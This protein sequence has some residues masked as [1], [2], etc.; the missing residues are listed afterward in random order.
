MNISKLTIVSLFFIFSVSQMQAVHIAG[1]DI[2]Y[3]NVGQDSFLV[4]LNLFRDCS[5]AVPNSSENIIFTS[6]CGDNLSQ[7]LVRQSFF[8]VS[9][10]CTNSI[11]NSTC[12]G[13]SLSAYEQHVYSGIVVLPAL[14]NSWTM[15]WLGCCRKGLVSNLVNSQSLYIYIYASLYSALD[16]TNTSPYF[17]S[18]PSPI[19][20]LNQAT[21]FNFGA[22]DPDGDSLVYSMSPGYDNAT[23]LIPYL[24][25]YT[26]NQPLPG[27]NLT[28]D[29]KTGQINFT[30]TALG[31]YT[32][33]VRVSEYDRNTGLLLGSTSRD[34][35]VVVTNS[36]QS[37]PV[38]SAVGM[39]NLGDGSI[40]NGILHICHG[41]S[42]NFNITISDADLADSLTVTHSV[43]DV[44]D[45]SAR[46]TVIGTNPVVI[47]VKWQ[48]F[49]FIPREFYLWFQVRDSG[50]PFNGVV[51]KAF[52]FQYYD[53][54]YANV[55]TTICNGDSIQLKAVGGT[56][57]SWSVISGV[58]IN[59]NPASSGYNA[60]CFQC[61]NPT[62][63]PTS[64]TI[65]RVVSNTNGP[66]GNVDTVI[67]NV[68]N[69]YTLTLP[70]DT[71]ICSS[72]EIGLFVHCLPS[73]SNY[74]YLWSNRE[75]LNDSTIANPI[76]LP[77]HTQR[78]T[79][80]VNNGSGC[81][82]ENSVKITL[83]PSIPI[84]FF[85]NGDSII[86]LGQSLDLDIDYPLVSSASTY[87]STINSVGSTTFSGIIGSGSS[88]TSNTGFPS[89]YGRYYW[90]SKHQLLY[91]VAE[92]NAMGMVAGSAINSI[93]FDVVS[94]G[95]PNNMDNMSIRIG[96]TSDTV[97]NGGF[98]SGLITV[99]PNHIYNTVLG[100]NVHT[101]S[102]GYLWDGVSSVVVEICSNNSGYS[103]L[104][105]SITR[106]STTSH[107][108]VVYYRGDN[109][110]VC[111]NSTATVSYNRPNTKFEY[112]AT[113]D[114][115][116]YSYTWSPV[117]GS[118]SSS[119]IHA[120]V[121]P[122]SDI[123]Y[124]VMV[125]DS[126]GLCFDTVTKNIT[127]SQGSFDA[128]FLYD[129]IVCL[130]AGLQTFRPIKSG[131]IFTGSGVSHS[132]V[133][134]PSMAG[135]G[136][137]D[138]NYFIP[139]PALC[140]NDSTMSIT[141]LPLPDASFQAVEVC[142][143]ATNIFLNAF[144]PG[145]IWSG[146]GIV[147]SLSGEFSAAGLQLGASEVTY[148]FQNPCQNSDTVNIRIIEPF[149]ITIPTSAIQLCEES[150]V[151]LLQSI[152]F[153]GASNQ[154]ANP[155]VSFSDVNGYVDSLGNFSAQGVP[156][157][158]YQ[159]DVIVSDSFDNCGVTQTFMINVIASDFATIIS[160]PSYCI[161]QTNAKI[162]V[163]PWLYG[164]GVAFT[165]RPL[166]SLGIN[167]T[168]EITAYGQNGEFSP[169]NSG[170]GSWELTINYTNI[171]GCLGTYVDTI[172]VLQ[173]P[174]IPTIINTGLDLTANAGV[175]YGYQW[176]DCEA[177]M[178]PIVGA[179]R[180]TY[181]PRR[182]G[183]FAVQIKAGNCIETSDCY[184]TWPV[185]INNITQSQDVSVFPNPLDDKLN[186][187]WRFAEEVNIQVLDNTGKIV[188]SV[189]SS[190]SQVILSVR[191]LSPGVYLIQVQGEYTNFSQKIVKL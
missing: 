41:D 112:I 96:C 146:E 136:A 123:S 40:S 139:S 179:N 45:T 131:G 109:N 185:G 129:S 156:V 36:S 113:V 63:F 81:I 121:S 60:T 125:T 188:K 6:S 107:A 19:T 8:E 151:N 9:S 39:T 104:A 75:T 34:L 98:L 116:T 4:T 120:T 83:T 20:F 82:K 144:V 2:T 51:S 31:D 141:V 42:L 138:I 3:V 54:L 7:D 80:T 160:E 77:L 78:Y 150:T 143:G 191:D 126:I 12:N 32:L 26:Y 13:G 84:G 148:A 49:S 130:N 14:C 118:I 66:C 132:G 35:L 93:G 16:S 140:S 168:L 15:S 50:C 157:G 128:G 53:G 187:E 142:Q 180:S 162:Y 17:V 74:S 106:Y 166:G 158:V 94:V 184:E 99:V 90:G 46:V 22:I 173:A 176:L 10:L 25:T 24:G 29:S 145:G 134:D 79:V 178:D 161:S 117:P 189:I 105:T 73:G 59:T 111:N 95:T 167:D 57:F 68:S 101:F 155:K 124:S 174:T 44:L 91:T 154:G 177:N 30:P 133:F 85:I 164:A 58:P 48:S 11:P 67:V 183:Q 37:Q 171:S 110:T 153:S 72:E 65:Y 62:V 172:F 159:V 190:D 165:Q 56:S 175:G 28:L 149:Q 52:G 18:S 47:N 186:I 76:A 55:D 61:A 114:S 122:S 5:G 27:S 119:G 71:L 87:C 169:S 182:K 69:N 43:F 1:G 137:W 152:S 163:N 86:C 97:F 23:S 92:L 170:L 147:D 33:V 108:S 115:N 135:A 102:Q 103:S 70:N 100:W 89:V 38:F 64:T 21:S 181:S 88:V 127:V